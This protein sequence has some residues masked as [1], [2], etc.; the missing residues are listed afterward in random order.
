MPNKQ[1]DSKGFSTENADKERDNAAKGGPAI[2]TG[3]ADGH[4]GI[5]RP[6]DEDLQTQIAAKGGKHK[7]DEKTKES[8]KRDD[9]L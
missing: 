2:G 6:Y 7:K 5:S 8:K 1:T 9:S 3:I 4:H